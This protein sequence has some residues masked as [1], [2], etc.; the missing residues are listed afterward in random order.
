MNEI[1]ICL[2]WCA[3][4]VT[5]IAAVAAGACLTLRRARSSTGPLVITTSLLLIG[6]LSAL[7]FSP[8]PRWPVLAALPSG[9][10][11]SVEPTAVAIAGPLPSR[12]EQSAAWASSSNEIAEPPAAPSTEQI[13]VDPGRPKTTAA[14]PPTIAPAPA[15]Q[16]SRWPGIAASLFLV[17][18]GIGCLWLSAGLWAVRRHRL[19]SRPVCDAALLELADRLRGELGCRRDVEIRQSD[20]LASAATFGWW[21]PLILLP[22]GWDGWTESERRVVLA[23]ELAHVRRHDFLACLGAQLGLVLHFYHP[24]VHWLVGRL[25]LEQEL[26]ADRAAAA[27]AGGRQ[28]YL[29]TLA[30]LALKQEDRAVA[31]PARALLPTRRTLLRRIETL[32]RPHKSAAAGLP[33]IRTAVVVVLL[34]CGLA[35]AGLRSPLPSSE[36]TA[37]ETP[38]P[39]DQ[40]DET[41]V[42]PSDAQAA[43]AEPLKEFLARIEPVPRSC[44]NPGEEPP[45]PQPANR[46]PTR[47]VR[48]S[49]GQ[50]TELKL[51]G[52]ELRP[53]DFRLMGQLAHLEILNFSGANVTNE[54]LRHL[55]NLR[56]LR[57]LILEE[58]DITGAGLVH[59]SRMDRLEILELRKTRLA[60]EDLR[61]LK[62]LRNLRRVD[63]NRNAID[64]AGLSYLAGLD[65]LEALNLSETRVTDRGLRHLKG[66]KNLRSI[67]LDD[68]GVSDAGLV[69]LAEFPRLHWISSPVPTIEELIRRMEQGDFEA[70]N[71]ML[72][73]GLLMPRRG[74][75]ERM[76]LEPLP[77]S[78]RDRTRNRRRYLLEMHWTVEAE[79][80]DDV[81]F[82]TL[83]VERGAI[84]AHEIGIREIGLAEA[85]KPPGD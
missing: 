24:L 23:H 19:H 57:H 65:R 17:G 60:G 21:R 58:T 2:L 76:K 79:K 42:S 68:T 44:Q 4:Q 34:L 53:G 39:A 11:T 10:D 28:S 54:D 52:R 84:S 32:R 3:A 83:A 82:A 9:S 41:L 13:A 33:G 55:S 25:H 46:P 67:T 49:Q 16:R 6:A 45:P 22:G 63:L 47:H 29:K 62:G 59:V 85:E 69:Y 35:A 12:S 20:D 37:E 14:I 31:W 72:S 15:A 56:N 38:P 78:E 74:R 8:W 7:A 5:L 50:I 73:I 40:P 70:A 77:P 64:D 26:A 75:F 18:A 27:V 71:D 30:G 61:H 43:I 36:A 48:N 66:L 80:L 51:Q 1:G 81:F